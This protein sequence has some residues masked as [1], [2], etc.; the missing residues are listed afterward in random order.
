[1]LKK[2]N[3]AITLRIQEK[4]DINQFI[5]L[6]ISIQKENSATLLFYLLTLKLK[7]EIKLFAD[8]L[9]R[10]LKMTSKCGKNI[11]DLMGHRKIPPAR[12]TAGIFSPLCPIFTTGCFTFHLFCTPNQSYSH[13]SRIRLHLCIFIWSCTSS[14]QDLSGL[15][16]YYWLEVQ[17]AYLVD[18]AQF[19]LRFTRH[20]TFL[21]SKL[22]LH[23][24][25]SLF[26]RV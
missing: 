10:K 26:T 16:K 19:L 17:L 12:G 6:L 5:D 25:E 1:M 13:F 9:G 8:R 14:W 15:I 22:V 20:F 11:S 7:H 3:R 21:H 24:L 2:R 23:S 4:H 18:F